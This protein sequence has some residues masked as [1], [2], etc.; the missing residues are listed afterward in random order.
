MNSLCSS[1]MSFHVFAR[2]DSGHFYWDF[3]K[4]LLQNAS[5]ISGYYCYSLRFSSKAMKSKFALTIPI[6][7]KNGEIMSVSLSV[8]IY[9][10]YP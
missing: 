2:H 10:Y 5:Q 9:F 3:I 4:E 8:T 7:N 1:L 6:A